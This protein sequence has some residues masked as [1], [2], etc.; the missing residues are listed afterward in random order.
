MTQPPTVLV[1]DDQIG[2][3]LWLIRDLQGRGYH[4]VHATNERTARQRL[5]AVSLGQESYRLAIVDIAVAIMDIED[6]VRERVNF[7]ARFLEDSAVAGLRLCEYAR[8]E[9]KLS[10]RELPIVCLSI[11][12][13]DKDVETRLTPLGIEV[14]ER[15]SQGPEQSIRRYL[16][17]HLPPLKPDQTSRKA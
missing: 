3:V 13:R 9:L 10:K 11:R 2:E 7:D 16:D 1:V 15:D 4:V 8:N 6:M 17:Q 14:F 12:A 5:L